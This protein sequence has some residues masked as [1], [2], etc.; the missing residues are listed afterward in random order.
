MEI[1]QDIQE[2]LKDMISSRPIHEV[3][4]KT[5]SKDVYNTNDIYEFKIRNF[6]S[7]YGRN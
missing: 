1:A 5:V 6:L 4:N 3:N 7:K 2:A